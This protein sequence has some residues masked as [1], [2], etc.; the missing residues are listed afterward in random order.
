MKEIRNAAWELVDQ[1]H[2]DPMAVEPWG[3]LYRFPVYAEV[4]AGETVLDGFSRP[5]TAPKGEGTY[6]LFEYVQNG[7]HQYFEWAE[8]L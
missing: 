6:T 1:H 7:T 2:L 4:S 3:E 5:H 8:E